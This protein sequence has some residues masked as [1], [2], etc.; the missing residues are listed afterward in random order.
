[1]AAPTTA[2]APNGA[3]PALNGTSDKKTAKS[4]NALRRQ[5]AKA[6][7]AQGDREGS[8]A[9]TGYA[10]ETDGETH[11][12][13]QNVLGTPSEDLTIDTSD[14]A[15][16]QFAA[17]MDKFQGTDADAEEKKV[18]HPVVMCGVADILYRT[19]DQKDRKSSIRT[20]KTTMKRRGRTPSQMPRE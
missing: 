1:M 14:P 15:Y 12:E 4:K 11:H 5:K 19:T 17:I 9:T 8:V 6:K 20:R 3:N 13:G 18:G 10:T 16:A 7:K 2:T